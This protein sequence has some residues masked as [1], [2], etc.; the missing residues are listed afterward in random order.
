MRKIT[1]FRRLFV[2]G[3]ILFG[4]M[5]SESSHAQFFDTLPNA[6]TT[7]LYMS[8][9][10]IADYNGNGI[11]DIVTFQ[12]CVGPLCGLHYVADYSNDPTVSLTP[13]TQVLS[14]LAFAGSMVEIVGGDFNGDGHQDVLVRTHGPHEFRLVPG[15]GNGTFGAPILWGTYTQTISE[16][17]TGD[18]NGD[19]RTDLATLWAFSPPLMRVWMSTPSGGL[20]LVASLSGLGTPK[21]G[22]YNGD[23]YDDIAMLTAPADSSSPHFARLLRG[24]ATGLVF[25]IV[26]LPTPTGV[27]RMSDPAD[28]NG[29]GIDDILVLGG[30]NF[31]VMLGA[32]TGPLSTSSSV[33][34]FPPLA[35]PFVF[36]A[37][38]DTDGNVDIVATALLPGSPQQNVVLMIRNRGAGQFVSGNSPIIW[39]PDPGVALGFNKFDSQ[40]VRDLDGDGDM[41]LLLPVYA[42]YAPPTLLYL[43]N[44]A[45]FGEGCS[46]SAGVPT[47]SI[48]APYPGNP[49]FAISVSGAAPFAPAICGISLATSIPS[50]CGLLIDINP[51]SLVLPDP[52]SG[53]TM[54]DALGFGAITG[55][56]PPSFSGIRVFVQ[57]AVWDPAAAFSYGGAD[58]SLSPGRT[59]TFF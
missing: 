44:L 50:P 17:R 46:G 6:S 14:A 13:S 10:I 55:S 53:V 22:D 3:C 11:P 30:G 5:G 57:W 19:G 23:G 12:G 4:S 48:G 24:G 26:S 25:P 38:M 31:H 49:D 36:G 39:Q 52:M 47:A 42:F 32:A 59:M 9:P 21:V 18:F 35:F 28:F 29:D 37:D 34:N 1:D 8:P 33:G 45:I 27:N 51:G 15:T 2:L 16:C 7:F 58:F 54:T 20:T 56:V 40:L 43:R 41:D